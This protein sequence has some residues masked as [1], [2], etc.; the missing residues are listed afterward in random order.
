MRELTERQ[1]EVLSFIT[2]YVNKHAYPPTIR[3]I[4]DH[5]SISVKGAYDHLSALKKKNRLRYG[6]KRSRA[7]EVIRTEEDGT[8]DDALRVPI[9]GHVAA[10]RPILA[11]ENWDGTVPVPRSMLRKDG[12]FFA[13]RVKGDSM[14]GAGI[15]DGDLAIIE[16]RE[17]A[18]DGEIVVA[19]V[20]E[21]VTLKRFFKESA[22][23]RLQAENP[24]YSPIYCRDVR[25]L[26]KLAC[27]LRRYA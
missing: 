27:L 20:E 18:K 1:R 7:I 6:D 19:V 5:F 16:K 10:G 23:I 11:E 17:A 15:V 14:E 26:G 21:A 22:R 8:E 9:L 4:A 12:S 25:I 2:S 13:L 3:E 24:A